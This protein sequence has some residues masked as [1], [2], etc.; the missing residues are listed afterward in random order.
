MRSLKYLSE[1]VN[2]GR[3]TNILILT[4]PHRHD[5]VT[6]L[7]INNEVQTFNRKL[8]KIMKPKDNVRILEHKLN[9]EDFTQRGLNLNASFKHKVVK[10]MSQNSFI[11]Q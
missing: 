5:L 4:A 9:T 10:L 1:F 3:N 8:H 2:H 6:T 11:H 7:C